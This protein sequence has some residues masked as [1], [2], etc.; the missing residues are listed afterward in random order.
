VTLLKKAK[1]HQRIKQMKRT[2]MK[3]HLLNPLTILGL[4]RAIISE[5]C[6]ICGLIGEGDAHRSSVFRR[7]SRLYYWRFPHRR[8]GDLA[9]EEA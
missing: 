3:Q 6:A 7:R 8:G 2:N 4:F 1:S 5:I 9:A